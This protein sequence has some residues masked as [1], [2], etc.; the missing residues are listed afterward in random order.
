MRALVTGCAGF[1]GSHLVDS[2]LL[3]GYEVVGMDC[4]ADYY[5]RQIKKTNI[6]NALGHPNFRLIE[7]DILDTDTDNFPEV[8]CV[9]HLAAQAGVRASWGKNFESYTRNNIE[10][11]QRLLE[12]Y[13]G[14]EIQKF[15]YASSSSVYGEVALP[16]R[17]NSLLKP[18]SPYGVTKLAAENLCNLYYR[19]YRVPVISLRYFTVYGPKQRPDM[20]IHRFVQAVINGEEITIYGDGEQTRDFTYVD[21]VIRATLLAANSDLLGEVL[22]IGSGAGI[23]VNQLI[24]KIERIIG[25]KAKLHYIEGQKGDV[26]DTLADISKAKETLNWQPKVRIEQ[27]LERYIAWFGSVVRE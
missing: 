7:Q 14:R 15:V 20:A 6:S 25:K 17:E 27:G 22:N 4:F 13:K 16:M 26:R 11:T 21:E 1:I 3:M 18:A 9:F 2:L 10:A 12:I 23:S 24:K 19:N 8:G 5:P